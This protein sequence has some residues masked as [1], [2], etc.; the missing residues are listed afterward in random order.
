MPDADA[1]RW[2]K[3]YQEARYGAFEQPRQFLVENEA[4]L[5]RQGQAIDLAMG[6]GGNAGFLLGRGLQVIGVDI[7]IVA[8]RLAKESYPALMAAVADLTRF[9]L[10]PYRFDLI[11]NFYYLQ[12]D[13][14]PFIRD[15]LRPGGV[16]VYETLTVDMRNVH[17]EI[18]TRYLLQPGELRSAFPGLEVLLYQ[19]G[20]K[21]KAG[22]HPKAVAGLIARKPYLYRD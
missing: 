2:N 6:L 5:P 21:D 8:A 22:E 12:R 16:V 9:Y 4:L 20:W 19:E 17:P 10:P 11:L 15:A 3:R 13:L 14:W 1:E 7:S 18:D